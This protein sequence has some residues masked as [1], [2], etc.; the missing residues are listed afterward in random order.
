MFFLAVFAKKTNTAL[1]PEGHSQKSFSLAEHKD[2]KQKE[3]DGLALSKGNKVCPSPPITLNIK[4]V[5]S[6]LV[7]AQKKEV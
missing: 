3:T 5:K 1:K 2:W 6:C 4:H 7:D